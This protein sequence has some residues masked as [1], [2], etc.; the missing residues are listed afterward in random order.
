MPFGVRP[1]PT[2]PSPRAKP[3]PQPPRKACKHRALCYPPRSYTG[4]APVWRSGPG[5]IRSRAGAVESALR[6]QS[7][8]LSRLTRAC[9][10]PVVVRQIM[11][12]QTTTKSNPTSPPKPPSLKPKATG[13]RPPRI[14]A[15]ASPGIPPRNSACPPPSTTSR[16]WGN[17]PRGWSRHRVIG[18]L[19]ITD[20][21]SGRPAA[22][23]YPGAV[24]AASFLRLRT[25]TEATPNTQLVV[26]IQCVEPCP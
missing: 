16:P 22:A 19:G 2:T 13:A 24:R 10:K 9:Q 18:C 20:Q 23:D 8:A 21:L 17:P 25:L 1:S 6:P 4:H 14:M 7:V 5:G 12:A 26:A 3:P 15:W 11:A